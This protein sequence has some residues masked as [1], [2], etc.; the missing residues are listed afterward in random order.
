M[1]ASEK[2]E[3][4]IELCK[5]NPAQRTNDWLEMKK[6]TVGGSEMAAVFGLNPY[7]PVKTLV[8]TKSGIYSKPFDRSIK[9]SWGNLF[10]RVCKS[11]FKIKYDITVLADTVTYRRGDRISYSPDGL[12][13][14]NNLD[15]LNFITSELS[16]AEMPKTGVALFE[17]KCPY[18]RVPTSQVPE[19]YTPQVKTGLNVIDAADFGIFA[20][21]VFKACNFEDLHLENGTN[22]AITKRTMPIAIGFI[23]FYRNRID[24]E[25]EEPEG[26]DDSSEYNHCGFI[27][28]PIQ[29]IQS[30]DDVKDL[31][32]CNPDWLAE[33]M[34]AH[35][36]GHIK[37]RYSKPI[38]NTTSNPLNSIRLGVRSILRD[39][40][41]VYIIGALPWKLYSAN[42]HLLKKDT[43]YLSEG[44]NK[45]MLD[46]FFKCVDE[47]REFMRAWKG[48][49]VPY[50]SIHGIY[51]E[52]YPQ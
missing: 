40:P 17:F 48:N 37:T 2:I 33:L 6:S 5:K 12:G 44:A 50:E 28:D 46:T 16:P 20:E 32:K 8:L 41:G 34:A 43:K 10:E 38:I 35:E 7:C 22:S 13:V 30:V 15:Q 49:N 47:C 42:M 45:S 14:V 36:D 26:E 18:S 52:H 29:N 11:Y 21:F 24:I 4:F 39:N 1:N 9:T 25:P 3:N 19:Y 31:S 27:P 23:I 51:T